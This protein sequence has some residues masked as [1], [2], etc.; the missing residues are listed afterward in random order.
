M[1]HGDRGGAGFLQGLFSWHAAVQCNQS[2]TSMRLV[3]GWCPR[4]QVDKGFL[5]GHV[6]QQ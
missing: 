6:T 2:S 4:L 5:R 3:Q 1:E